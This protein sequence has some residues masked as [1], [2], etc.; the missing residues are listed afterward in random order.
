MRPQYSVRVQLETLSYVSQM[1]F[2]YNR[3][4]FCLY[5]L[6]EACNYQAICLGWLSESFYFSW[7]IGESL[8]QQ[9]ASFSS[10]LQKW[11]ICLS[12]T[13][14]WRKLEKVQQSSVSLSR[15]HRHFPNE[16]NNECQTEVLK[17][18]TDINVCSPTNS[19]I[20]SNK[21]LKHVG[22]VGP[23]DLYIVRAL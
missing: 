2:P 18:S 8:K 5:I 15:Q 23:A 14:L 1:K 22:S 10:I 17:N 20:A 19:C 7:F 12:V 9:S 16:Y 13:P 4:V 11:V 6:T 3:F 21:P